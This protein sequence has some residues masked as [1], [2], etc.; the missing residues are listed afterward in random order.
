ME[1]FEFIQQVISQLQPS[2][3]VEDMPVQDTTGHVHQQHITADMDMPPFDK[4]AMDGYACRKQDIGNKLKV[5]E[6]VAAGSVPVNE[7]KE[8]QC[9]KIMTGAKVPPGA[10]CVFMVEDAEIIDAVNVRCTNLNT[11]T[12][13]CYQGEDH[14]IGDILLEKGQIIKPEHLSIIASAGFTQVKVS[15]MPGI[16]LI[17]TGSELVEPDQK[18]GSGKIRNSNAVQITALCKKMHLDVNYY[19]IVS[20]N[21]KQLTNVFNQAMDETDMI[22]ITGGASMG[23]FD[24]VPELLSQSGFEIVWERTGLKPGNPMSFSH[25]KNKYCFGLSGNPVSCLV[26]F[27]YIVKP[28]LYQLLGG[29][30]L[31]P[32][33]KGEMAMDFYR[34]NASRFG[35]IPVY[36]NPQGLIELLPFN[37]SAHLNVLAGANALM[38]IATGINELKKGGHAYVRPF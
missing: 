30:Y 27:E 31:P 1:S 34:K 22:M 24:L 15:Q 9:A 16:G 32:V 28:V 13:I 23:D 26:Q 6:I 12:N 3:R 25:N 37:G 20:D 36:I 21:V 29:N 18:P 38:E 35:I 8:N 11:K 2:F 33:V 17:V 10:D 4:S 19:G 5:I 14:R 7:I